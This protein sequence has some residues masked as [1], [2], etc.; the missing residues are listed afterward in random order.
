LI[1]A[2]GLGLTR[3]R[4]L[5]ASWGVFPVSKT[6]ALK[7]Q[8]AH[9]FAGDIMSSQFYFAHTPGTKGLAEGIVTQ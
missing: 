7:D 2:E 9:F 4:I 8:I 3:G 6:E 1:C 5:T